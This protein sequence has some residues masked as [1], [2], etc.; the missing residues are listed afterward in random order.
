MGSPFPWFLKF[1]SYAAW[2]EVWAI[3]QCQVKG[4]HIDITRKASGENKV[5]SL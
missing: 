3:A 2:K 4:G 5:E 1:A